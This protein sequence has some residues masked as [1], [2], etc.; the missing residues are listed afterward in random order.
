M[1]A[2]ENQVSLIIEKWYNGTEKGNYTLTE[3]L[4]FLSM[5]FPRHFAEQ[6]LRPKKNIHLL[7]SLFQNKLSIDHKLKET[8]ALLVFRA[9]YY[10]ENALL[11]PLK[12]DI[13]NY[14]RSVSK[15][16]PDSVVVYSMRTQ[17]NLFFRFFEFKDRLR[18]SYDSISKWLEN[19]A[20]GIEI[21]C[22]LK[23]MAFLL[24]FKQGKTIQ[25]L[26]LNGVFLAICSLSQN[27]QSI[28]VQFNPET[29]KE[30]SLKNAICKEEKIL[31]R[32]QSLARIKMS[33]DDQGLMLSYYFNLLFSNCVYVSNAFETSS[34]LGLILDFL[35]KI[36]SESC[37]GLMLS[38]QIPA[39]ISSISQIS[40]K[41]IKIK[42]LNHLL[43]N[44]CAP[45]EFFHQNYLGGVNMLSNM[46]SGQ[47]E[48]SENW[49]DF[50]EQFYCPEFILSQNIFTLS[51]LETLLQ[52]KIF[53][54]LKRAEN[55]IELLNKILEKLN[56]FE[57]DESLILSLKSNSGR[58]W[59][60]NVRKTSLDPR[61]EE[62]LN[63]INKILD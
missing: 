36:E 52:K 1:E 16:F 59:L 40:D 18:E 23:E 37:L 26:D 39:Y 33:V 42:F 10:A 24:K 17:L 62:L 63:S 45:K 35:T 49:E 57:K 34:P 58:E 61:I 22:L 15:K 32:L 53:E 46:V 56:K 21:R 9:C 50:L 8:L 13:W 60:E 20:W 41:K 12:E 48:L 19:E 28:T 7:I 54:T 14:T 47:S 51:E 55:R 25:N 11:E 2:L 4:L 43:T 30:E 31:N 29:S 38:I 27:E 44:F 5:A 3:K 6:T